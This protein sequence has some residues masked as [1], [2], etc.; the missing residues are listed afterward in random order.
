MAPM[1]P[2]KDTVLFFWE[3]PH[4]N[5][6]CLVGFPSLRRRLHDRMGL[7][8]VVDQ[9]KHIEEGVLTPS[10]Y[11]SVMALGLLSDL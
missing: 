8:Q 5:D 3:C 4:R 2:G 6:L 10:V 1:V 11:L 9:E 7:A